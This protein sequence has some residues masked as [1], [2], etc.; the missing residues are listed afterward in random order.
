MG[1]QSAGERLSWELQVRILHS[2][3][4]YNLSPFDSDIVCLYQNVDINKNKCVYVYVHVYAYM[5]MYM[6][7][8]MY[9]C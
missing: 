2:A 9:M 3:Q 8:Y 6:Y 1:I 7:I 5:Y 4:E